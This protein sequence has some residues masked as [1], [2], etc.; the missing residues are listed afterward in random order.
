MVIICLS[1]YREAPKSAVMKPG[2]N[3]E[4]RKHEKAGMPSKMSG[5]QTVSG[6]S[7]PAQPG[8][9]PRKSSPNKQQSK[10]GAPLKSGGKSSR[11][12]QS[13]KS[14]AP[15]KGPQ[16][17]PKMAPQIKAPVKSEPPAKPPKTAPMAKVNKPGIDDRGRKRE[18]LP[19]PGYVFSNTQLWP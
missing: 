2:S 5:P 1:I 9:Q 8:R 16:P 11:D 14:V 19:P 15:V 3:A 18:R 13:S 17:L 10:N 4:K 12:A 7:K 6:M